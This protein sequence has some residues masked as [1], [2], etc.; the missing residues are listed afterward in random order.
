MPQ[1]RITRKDI[2]VVQEGTT[3]TCSIKAINLLD[4]TTDMFNIVLLTGE[5]HI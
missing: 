1:L 3:L 4:F 5:E 2:D